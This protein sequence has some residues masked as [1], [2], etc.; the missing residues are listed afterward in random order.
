[1]MWT[2][3]DDTWLGYVGFYDAVCR[4]VLGCCGVIDK[5]LEREFGLLHVVMIEWMVWLYLDGM[6]VDSL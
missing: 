4:R 2:D 1:M 3:G 6:V 5:R